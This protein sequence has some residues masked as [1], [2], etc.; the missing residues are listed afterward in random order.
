MKNYFTRISLPIVILFSLI[1]SC[2]NFKNMNAAST[3]IEFNEERRLNQK[4][5]LEEITLVNNME[6]LT[7]LY[8][9]LKDP[10]IPRSAPIPVFD[11][12]SEMMVVIKPKL[13]KSVYADIEIEGVTKSNSKITVSY[14][15]VE[16]WEFQQNK[17]I[18]PIV[19]IRISEKSSEIQL[20]KIN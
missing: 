13:E 20:N 18:D 14:K 10:Q 15:E 1:Y 7:Q 9:K 8:A 16:N 12:S 11:E 19:I 5:D 3:S 2:S 17:W 4:I 6:E